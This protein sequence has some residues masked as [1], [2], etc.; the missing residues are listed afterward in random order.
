M[1]KQ[2]LETLLAEFPEAPR[3]IAERS[4]DEARELMRL[5]RRAFPG[6]DP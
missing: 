6:T 3:W 5:R 1:T 4:L 2:E